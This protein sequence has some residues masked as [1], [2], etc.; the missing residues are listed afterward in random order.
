MAGSFME[1]VMDLG[2]STPGGPCKNGALT[3][4]RKET[5]IA[6]SRRSTARSTP[7]EE[8]EVVRQRGVLPSRRSIVAI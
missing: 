3:G 2:S 4:R 7:V 6:G 1:E 5:S 8:D